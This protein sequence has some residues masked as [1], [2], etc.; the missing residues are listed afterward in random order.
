MLESLLVSM[1]SR[2][3][4]RQH[5][6]D[7]KRYEIRGELW[8]SLFCLGFVCF[9]FFFLWPHRGIVVKDLD[10]Y[11]HFTLLWLHG[12]SSLKKFFFEIGK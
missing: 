5:I 1:C 11:V 2:N 6:D 9:F 8:L 4:W 7:F 10:H 12:S 3:A